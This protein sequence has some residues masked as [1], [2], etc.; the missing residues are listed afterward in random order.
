MNGWMDG[1]VD[2]WMSGE[3]LLM[4][5]LKVVFVFSGSAVGCLSV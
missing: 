5:S 2:G 4:V 3:P 1:Q